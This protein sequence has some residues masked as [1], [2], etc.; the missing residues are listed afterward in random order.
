MGTRQVSGTSAVGLQGN[1]LLACEHFGSCQ[2]ACTRAGKLKLLYACVQLHVA[3]HC[4]LASGSAPASLLV[5]NL[6]QRSQHPT[7]LSVPAL[8]QP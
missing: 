1:C 2:P 4:L 5:L 7:P 3:L 6:G 8:Q